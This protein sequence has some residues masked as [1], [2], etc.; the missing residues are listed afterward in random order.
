MGSA[1]R[2][3]LVIAMRRILNSMRMNLSASNVLTRASRRA[4]SRFVTV[5]SVCATLAFALDGCGPDS[6]KRVKSDGAPS[7]SARRAAVPT[8]NKDSAYRGAT[9]YAGLH[10]TTLPTRLTN[11]GGAVLPRTKGLE[12]DFAF[13][14]VKTPRGDMIWLDSLDSKSKGKTPTR[15]VRAELLIPPLANDERLFMASCDAATKFDPRI[16]A[17]VV[18]EP[19]VTKFTQIRQAWRANNVSGRF[20]VI[21]IAG[22]TCEEP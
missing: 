21:P 18:N 14:H 13:V 9:F 2:S 8:M 5:V 15:V 1:A 12:G 20:D 4:P 6:S 16:V 3:R 10:Y 19:K 17:I 7:D 22:V 11:E